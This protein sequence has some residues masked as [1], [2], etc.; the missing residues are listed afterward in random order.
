MFDATKFRVKLFFLEHFQ[1]IAMSNKFHD[2]CMYVSIRSL[3][4]I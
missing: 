4:E 2:K 1:R 3:V